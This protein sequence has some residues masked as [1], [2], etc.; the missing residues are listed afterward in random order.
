MDKKLSSYKKLK[1]EN[2]DLRNDIFQLVECSDKYSGLEV[3]T[4]WQIIFDQDR[5]FWFGNRDN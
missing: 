5:I 3:K 4:K 1:K 2:Q